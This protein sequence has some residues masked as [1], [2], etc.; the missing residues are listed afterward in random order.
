MEVL[1]L[2]YGRE[3]MTVNLGP[4]FWQL[5]RGYKYL[6]SFASNSSFSHSFAYRQIRR[7]KAVLALSSLLSFYK[8]YQNFDIL[9]LLLRRYRDFASGGGEDWSAAKNSSTLKESPHSA[10][11]APPELFCTKPLSRSFDASLAI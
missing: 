9:T 10:M 8:N 2:S 11:E 7:E 6:L 3:S 5:I 1:A 4:Q